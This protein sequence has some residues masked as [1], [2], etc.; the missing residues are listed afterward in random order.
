MTNIKQI[1]IPIKLGN[2]IRA[3]KGQIFG[4]IDKNSIPILCL[5]G[6]LDNSNSKNNQN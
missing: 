1:D 6:Y 2:E 4:N 3:V 5:H